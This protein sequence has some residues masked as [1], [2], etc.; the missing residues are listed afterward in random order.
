MS[1]KNFLKKI[2]TTNNSSDN[3]GTEDYD[4]ILLELEECYRDRKRLQQRIEYLENTQ[5]KRIELLEYYI[6]QIK[7]GG[8]ICPVFEPLIKEEQ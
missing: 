6:Q 2:T 7:D 5:N 8:Q 3:I 4:K 1:L